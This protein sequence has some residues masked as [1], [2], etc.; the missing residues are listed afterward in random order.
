[1]SIINDLQ[2]FLQKKGKTLIPIN[3]IRCGGPDHRPEWKA[4]AKY[5][6][7]EYV[8]CNSS[9]T[10]RDAKKDC[11]QVI[12]E[13]L[14]KD[15]VHV[16]VF[17]KYTIS[18]EPLRLMTNNNNYYI[19]I[20]LDNSLYIWNAII[21]SGNVI[22]LLRG[23]GGPKL[24]QNSLLLL[25]GG[26]SYVET[27]KTCMKDSADFALFADV[28]LYID[29]KTKSA[30]PFTNNDMILIVSCDKSLKTASIILEAKYNNINISYVDRLCDLF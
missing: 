25:A 19:W 10:K 11:A 30:E 18:I 1:M 12:Y 27:T 4:Y 7:R 2:E 16:D 23:F 14:S 5:E 29:A 3:V 6:D 9:L 8:S 26:L 15:I 21:K 22:R 28:L 24:E 17:L 20:D 13:Q